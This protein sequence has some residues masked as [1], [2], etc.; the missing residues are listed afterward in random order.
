MPHSDHFV[1]LK[2][3]AEEYKLVPS[4]VQPESCSTTFFKH[5]VIDT[6]TSSK[7]LVLMAKEEQITTEEELTTDMKTALGRH[8]SPYAGN[9]KGSIIELREKPNESG[10]SE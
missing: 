7:D 8:D 9:L 3:R 6:K 5:I 4:N 10:M 1:S 2:Q